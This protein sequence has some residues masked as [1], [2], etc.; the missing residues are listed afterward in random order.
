MRAICIKD[1]QHTFIVGKN[2]FYYQIERDPIG[3]SDYEILGE[4]KSA[5]FWHQTEFYEYFIPIEQ[6]RDNLIDS[7]LDEEK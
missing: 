5:A 3:N 6:Y 1:Y 7:I 4:N 2:Y